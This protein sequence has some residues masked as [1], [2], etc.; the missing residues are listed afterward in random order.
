MAAASGDA[1][2]MRALVADNVVDGGLWFPDPACEQEFGAGE[3]VPEARLDAFAT[4]LAALKLQPS[5]RKDALPD[6]SVFDYAPGIEVE[7]RM[8]PTEAGGPPRLLWIGYAS[9]RATDPVQPLLSPDAFEALRRSGDRNGPVSTTAAATLDPDG[10]AAWLRVCIDDKGTVTQADPYAASSNNAYL[11]FAAAARMWTFEPFELAGQPTPACSMV[12]FNYPAA[13]AAKNE[14]LPFPPPPSPKTH[15]YPLVLAEGKA[16]E[17]QAGTRIAGTRNIAPDDRTKTLIQK[18]LH[19]KKLVASFML[20]LDESGTPETILPITSSGF[21][22]YD[23]K[24]LRGI[25]EWRYAPYKVDGEAVPV[26]TG[27]TFI[28]SQG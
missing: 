21:A 12:H 7:A 18:K 25:S 6:V 26:C 3:Q 2:Q 4:C 19:G 8:A 24:L 16:H 10:E 5:P 28:Y 20:C 27:V 9:R 13:K 15:R 17:L 22:D 11:A 1:H 14:M 23:A